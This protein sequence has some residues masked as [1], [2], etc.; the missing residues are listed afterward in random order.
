MLISLLVP[1]SA[2]AA[3]EVASVLIT[4]ETLGIALV[5]LV[6][7][8]KRRVLILDRAL[9]HTTTQLARLVSETACGD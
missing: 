8:H 3:L 4:V 1:Y 9:A 7:P 6:M 2:E 5:P